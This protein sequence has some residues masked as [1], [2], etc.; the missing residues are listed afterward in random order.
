MFTIYTR[1][2]IFIVIFSTRDSYTR[3]SLAYWQSE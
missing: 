3:N 2:N 1:C